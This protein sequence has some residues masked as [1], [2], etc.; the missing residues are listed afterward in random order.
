MKDSSAQ[1]NSLQM[2]LLPS[3]A[4]WQPGWSLKKTAPRGLVGQRKCLQVRWTERSCVPT[5]TSA[6]GRTTCLFRPRGPAAN[7]ILEQQ[8][9]WA[10]ARAGGAWVC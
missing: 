1:A 7:L 8:C 5:G 3:I 2:H 10:G 6:S 4:N 9:V